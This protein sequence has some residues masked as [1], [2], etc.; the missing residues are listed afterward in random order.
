MAKYVIFKKRKIYL[1]LSL[2]QVKSSQF[3][4]KEKKNNMNARTWGSVALQP[5]VAKI[6]IT[7]RNT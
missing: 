5:L 6:S 4:V 3:Y 2:Y 7:T 1:F